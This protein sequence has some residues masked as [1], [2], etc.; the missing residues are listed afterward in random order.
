LHLLDQIHNHRAKLDAS[1]EPYPALPKGF[2]CYIF[3]GF[4]PIFPDVKLAV[5]HRTMSDHH[6]LRQGTSSSAP[7][8]TR[9]VPVIIGY[10]SFAPPLKHPDPPFSSLPP[11]AHNYELKAKQTELSADASQSCPSCKNRPDSRDHSCE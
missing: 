7:C 5:S 8:P 1:H 9:H 4:S 3:F 6:C 10:Q 11:L 2:S